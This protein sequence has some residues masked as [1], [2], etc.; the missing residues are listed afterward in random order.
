MTMRETRAM[1]NPEACEL[2]DFFEDSF[3][4]LKPG[5]LNSSILALC[6]EFVQKQEHACSPDGSAVFG[7]EP[8]T[9]EVIHD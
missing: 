4:S 9:A 8:E 7:L 6:Q 3:R 2:A 1:E 5:K